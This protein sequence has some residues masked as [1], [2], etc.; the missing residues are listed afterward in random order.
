MG[1]IP[2]HARGG[3]DNSKREALAS[4]FELITTERLF[5]E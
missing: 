5:I 3:P 1:I 4:L 2:L